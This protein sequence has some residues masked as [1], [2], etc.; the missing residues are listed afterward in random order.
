MK[1]REQ[2]EIELHKKL[3]DKYFN[4]REKHPNGAYYNNIW[5]NL[6]LGMVNENP[7]KVLDYGCGSALFYTYLRKKFPKMNYTGVDLSPDMLKVAKSKFK[8]EKFVEGNAEKLPFENNSF[9]FVIGR[10]ILHHL[11][12]SDNG[13]KEVSRVLKKG[14]LFLV[15]ETHSNIFADILRKIA[16]KSTEHFDHEHKEFTKK[17]FERMFLSNNMEIVKEKSFGYLAFP[18]GLPDIMRILRIMPN[19]L[20]KILVKLDF[21]IEKIPILNKFSWHIIVVARKN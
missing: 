2:R 17:E 3:A 21:A 12:N 1:T 4:I 15:S 20:F 11:H 13:V 18:F 5:T 6:M 14:G 19:W 8:K 16:K 7:K 9:D 10:G